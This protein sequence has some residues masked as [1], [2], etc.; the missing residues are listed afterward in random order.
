M[1]GKF[2]WTVSFK[3][4]RQN[5]HN[6]FEAQEESFFNAID[7]S[8]VNIGVFNDH[9]GS[10][11]ETFRFYFI[12]PANEEVD[13]PPY[14]SRDTLY[15]TYTEICDFLTENSYTSS[16]AMITITI[17]KPKYDV[18]LNRFKH[19]FI[20]NMIL[21]NLDYRT[22]STIPSAHTQIQNYKKDIE[23]KKA[24]ENLYHLAI[25]S[26]EYGFYATPKHTIETIYYH[27]LIGEHKILTWKLTGL[28]IDL[29]GK[30]KSNTQNVLTYK[31]LNIRLYQAKYDLWDELLP[32]KEFSLQ[33]ES[34]RGAGTKSLITLLDNNYQSEISLED[35]RKDSGQ[36]LPND[37]HR[38]ANKVLNKL[39]WSINRKGNIFQNTPY[40]YSIQP[41]KKSF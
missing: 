27:H 24:E 17:N 4:L 1:S 5:F 36:D 11:V 12:N 39:N 7:S 10:I 26:S 16:S 34:R 40:T 8:S 37:W 15:E 23:S 32:G 18:H 31:S 9:E 20:E 14:T 33:S 41:W 13:F 3:Y 35:L 19:D 2:E 22:A 25:N 6:N 21:P 28:V 29:M 38:S 30:G